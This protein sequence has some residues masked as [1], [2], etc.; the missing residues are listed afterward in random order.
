M[1]ILLD[2]SW[3]L[4][5]F[6]A[7]PTFF[8]I[9]LIHEGSHALAAKYYGFSPRII[10]W[11]TKILGYWTFGACI[12]T[13]PI[14]CPVW[15]DPHVRRMI[16]RMPRIV[17]LIV[18]II[19]GVCLLFIPTGSAVFTIVKIVQV[20]MAIDFI[21]NTCGIYTSNESNDAWRSFEGIPSL[22]PY[23]KVVSMAAIVIVSLTLIM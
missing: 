10:P 20:A 14:G 19:T 2:I 21:V 5:F 16:S 1:N 18:L 4:V 3:S 13:F 23:V 15:A 17:N 6:L 12:W 11:P 7:I 9:T 8:L 22:I